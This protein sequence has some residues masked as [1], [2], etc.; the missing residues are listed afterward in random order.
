MKVLK[1]TYDGAVDMLAPMLS[2]YLACFTMIP[3]SLLNIFPFL[4]FQP[5]P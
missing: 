4:E 3:S 2:Y 1:G 5:P